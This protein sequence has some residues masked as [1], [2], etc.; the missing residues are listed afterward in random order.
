MSGNLGVKS[1]LI[2]SVVYLL[3]CI[4]IESER[5]SILLKF[6]V[7]ESLSISFYWYFGL[8]FMFIGYLILKAILYCLYRSLRSS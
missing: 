5:Q 8:I 7:D 4:V 6:N 3:V 1:I 2:A